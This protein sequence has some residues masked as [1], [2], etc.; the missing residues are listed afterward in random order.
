MTTAYTTPTMA[1]ADPKRRN[2]FASWLTR[3]ALLG[4]VYVIVA[5]LFAQLL[6]PDLN[7]LTR[8]VSEYAVGAYGWVMGSA[9]VAL[10]LSTAA[11]VFALKRTQRLAG[12][13]LV[14]RIG[15]EVASV[16]CLLAGLL[17][18]D[19]VGAPATPLGV[20]HDQAETFGF[21]GLGVAT[22]LFALRWRRDPIGAPN[23]R[24]LL[25]IGL[26]TVLAMHLFA[27]MSVFAPPDSGIPATL[28]RILLLGSV[29]W[30][31]LA[32]WQVQ[33]IATGVPREA[34]P[35]LLQPAGRATRF[36]RWLGW[37][38]V[39]GISYVIGVAMLMSLLRT[40]MNPLSNQLSEYVFG[41]FGWLMTVSF[42]A[43]SVSTLA[44]VVGLARTVAPQR[45]AWPGILW[46]A[47]WSVGLVVAGSFPGGPLASGPANFLHGMGAIT[48]FTGCLLGMLL[49]TDG[50]RHDPD[51]ASLTPIALTLVAVA[52]TGVAFLLVCSPWLNGLA[53][54]WIFTGALP[55]MWLAGWRLQQVAQRTV[56]KA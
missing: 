50:W 56:G 45:R 12:G 15:L 7:P 11:L 9:L 1:D 32:A 28:Q 20:L 39:A 25:P 29:I 22:L 37:T 52:I 8:Y 44:L 13:S 40:D 24:W 49:L 2:G 41:P 43:W 36:D 55:W 33:R 5:M 3:I 18:T 47:V 38:T 42:F 10:S 14:G 4:G 35:I 16:G 30:L 54:R 27:P 48:G 6:R 53:Q 31:L 46:L 19:L 17:P 34:A 51:W 21:A 23:V 26:V